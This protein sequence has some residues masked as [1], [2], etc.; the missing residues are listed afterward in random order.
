MAQ[1]QQAVEAVGRHR[2]IG[3]EFGIINWH[4]TAEGTAMSQEK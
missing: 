3:F 4:V 2:G 1:L